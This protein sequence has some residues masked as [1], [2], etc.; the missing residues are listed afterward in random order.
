MLGHTLQ[1]FLHKQILFKVLTNRISVPAELIRDSLSDTRNICKGQQQG[2]HS[3][4][5]WQSPAVQ[6]LRNYNQ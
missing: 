1:L 5:T 3:L 4:L 2:M 6:I